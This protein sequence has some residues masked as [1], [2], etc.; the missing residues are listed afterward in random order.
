M[1]QRRRIDI[2]ND[3]FFSCIV[4]SLQMS[5]Y[6]EIKRK[7]RILVPDSANLIGVIDTTGALEPNEVFIQ[8]K[9]DNFTI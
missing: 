5:N 9:Q 3:P 6:Q 4:S 7:G 2:L 8:L 1:A